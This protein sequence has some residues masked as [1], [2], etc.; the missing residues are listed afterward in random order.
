M[1]FMAFKVGFMKCF[2]SKWVY[3]INS[4]IF[5]EKICKDIGKNMQKHGVCSSISECMYM[6]K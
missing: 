5:T 4:I 1:I 6:G 2:N 3:L